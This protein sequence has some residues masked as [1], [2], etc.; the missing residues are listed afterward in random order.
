LRNIEIILPA[1]AGDAKV[2]QA[3]DQAVAEAGLAVTLRDTLKAFPGCI[4]WHVKN[5]RESGTLEITFWPQE[6]RAWFS[7]QSG[8][9]AA[10][11]DEKMNVLGEAIQKRLNANVKRK[12]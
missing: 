12:G 7:V 11:I 3:I 9:A 6:R 2:E 1:V 5:G 4:H 8:R 10:W